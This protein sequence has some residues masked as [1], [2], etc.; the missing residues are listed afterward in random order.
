MRSTLTTIS[1]VAL[2]AAG[3]APAAARPDAGP[4]S[5]RAGAAKHAAAMRALGIQYEQLSAQAASRPAPGDLAPTR[6]VRT[7]AAAPGFDWADAGI[8]AGLTVVLLLSGAGF[9]AVRRH[10]QMAPR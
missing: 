4:S 10:P 5:T 7:V 6:V 2:L 3:A 9:V 1:I 8:G